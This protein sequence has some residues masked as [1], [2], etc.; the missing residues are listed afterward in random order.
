MNTYGSNYGFFNYQAVQQ[1]QVNVYQQAPTYQAPAYQAPPSNPNP[2]GQ[3]YQMEL[4]ES[5]GQLNQTWHDFL[6]P[7]QPTPA[8][9]TPKKMNFKE[10]VNV[11]SHHRGVLDTANSKSKRDK[12]FHRRDLKAIVED[13]PD[14]P[15]RLKKASQFLLDNPAYYRRLRDAAGPG[16]GV[17]M[18]DFK[19]LGVGGAKKKK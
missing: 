5:L 7:P 13:N 1:Y 18:K 12:K 2:F 15:G 10:A 3:Q 14:V 8:Q 9:P 17:S 19:A 6:N 11:L 16:A 4:L